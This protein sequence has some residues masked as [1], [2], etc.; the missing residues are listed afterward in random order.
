MKS[1]LGL[2]HTTISTVIFTVA[3]LFFSYQL[4]PELALVLSMAIMIK[5][6]LHIQETHRNSELLQRQLIN[7]N[8]KDIFN[9][10]SLAAKNREL[11]E[12]YFIDE[13]TKLPNKNAL[14][15]TIKNR[16]LLHPLCNQYR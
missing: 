2:S 6:L 16:E 5:L 15:D 9:K 10:K 14:I 1:M 11:E 3:I 4:S 8:N 13:L 7:L 12:K